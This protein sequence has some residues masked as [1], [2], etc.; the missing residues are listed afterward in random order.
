MNVEIRTEAAQFFFGKYVNRISLQCSKAA[1]KEQASN[2][3]IIAA[4]PFCVG[5]F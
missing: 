5:F 3:H 4:E 2:R 1:K